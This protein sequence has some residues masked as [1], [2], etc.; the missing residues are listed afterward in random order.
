LTGALTPEIRERVGEFYRSVA[1]IFE[2]WFGSHKS[3]D[4]QRAYG[5]DII[6]FVGFLGMAWPDGAPGLFRISI[7]DVQAFRA[8]LVAR[9]AASKTINRRISSLSSFFKYLGGAAAERRLPINVPNPAHAQSISRENSDPVDETWALSATRALQLMD[10]RPGI[11]SSR[12]VIG[13]F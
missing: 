2:A 1:A 3:A 10:W 7:L 12:S 9:E 13:R 5:G 6:A 8:D 4:K 11:R